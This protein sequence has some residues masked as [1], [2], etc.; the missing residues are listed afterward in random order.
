[1]LNLDP[2][3]IRNVCIPHASVCCRGDDV[4]CRSVW[5][6]L[7]LLWAASRSASIAAH[8]VGE[9][10]TDAWSSLM[11]R[12]LYLLWFLCTGFLPSFFWKSA[13]RLFWL[14]ARHLRR[15]E[16]PSNP[17]SDNATDRGLNGQFI[18]S[19]IYQH[20]M[21]HKPWRFKRFKTW[22]VCMSPYWCAEK[23]F[24]ESIYFPFFL[25]RELFNGYETKKVGGW[26]R[27]KNH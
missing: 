6:W 10:M 12:L 2:T 9:W 4:V 11:R 21:K 17:P 26:W 18:C 25:L 22:Q 23:L 19:R 27:A 3:L 1:M 24:R 8:V 15:P 20:Q 14:L 5:F 7:F 13:A 16:H